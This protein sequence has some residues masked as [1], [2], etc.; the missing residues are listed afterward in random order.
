[1]VTQKIE[2][3]IKSIFPTRI[4]FDDDSYIEYLNVEAILYVEKKDVKWKSYGTSN[5]DA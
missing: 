4:S 3:F 1:M 2:K 5:P